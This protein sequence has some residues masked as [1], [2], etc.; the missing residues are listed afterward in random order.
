MTDLEAIELRQSRRSYLDTRVSLDSIRRIKAAIENYNRLSGL[1][2]QFIEDGHEAFQGFNLTYGM[3]SGVRSF[4]AI[5]GEVS[6]A[7]A[8]EKAG[9]YGELLV[10][11]ATKLGLGSCFVGGTFNRKHCPCTIKDNE[12]LVIIIPIGNVEAKKGFKENT[13]YKLVHRHTK[14]AQE[15]YSSDTQVPG[16][17]LEGIKA[18]QKAPSAMNRQPV[19]FTYQSGAVTAEVSKPESHEA[20]DLG[21]AKAHFELAAG[22]R[23]SFGNKAPFKKL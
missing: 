5:I 9:Y 11:E 19:H 20:I 18:V 7:Y 16:W 6:D 8:D 3:F 10:L 1:S 17:F 21:I 14:A 13:I 22:G 4:I 15:L 2:M 12:R 23:F